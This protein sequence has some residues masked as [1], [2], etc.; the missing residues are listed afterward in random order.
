MYIFN[1]FVC[2]L[3]VVVLYM[4]KINLFFLLFAT[5]TALLYVK[6]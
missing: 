5:F 4:Y 2:N 6:H 3:L 1:I